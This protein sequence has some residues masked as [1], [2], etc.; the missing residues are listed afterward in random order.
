MQS[1]RVSGEMQNLFNKCPG[2][3]SPHSKNFLKYLW[4]ITSCVTITRDFSQNWPEDRVC[5]QWLTLR[6]AKKKRCST[7]PKSAP[8]TSYMKLCKNNNI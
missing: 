1:H 8:A 2:E 6:T 7:N 4:F 5:L 3:L